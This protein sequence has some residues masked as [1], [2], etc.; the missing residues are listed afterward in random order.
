MLYEVPQVALGVGVGALGEAGGCGGDE[1][2]VEAE[3]E[4][5]QLPRPVVE[6]VELE[7]V[8]VPAGAD[9]EVGV[10]QQARHRGQDGVDVRPPG[11]GGHAPLLLLPD[12]PLDEAAAVDDVRAPAHPEVLGV[13]LPGGHIDHAAQ[14]AAVL[15]PVA[16]GQVVHRVDE[17]G[18]E[19]RHDPA[20][21]VDERDA[22]PVDVD[23]GVLGVGAADDQGAGAQGR[24]RRAR[25]RLDH[26]HRVAERA[27]HAAD[28]LDAEDAP[29][30]VRGL[31]LVD[32][33]DLIIPVAAVLDPQPDAGDLPLG[34]LDLLGDIQVAWIERAET[35]R[36]QRHAAEPV[37]ALG[38]GLC[39]LEEL[40]A[41]GGEG[42]HGDVAELPPGAH[43]DDGALQ[44]DGEVRGVD[45][46]LRGRGLG[47][48]E[49]EGVGE[50]EGDGGRALGVLGGGEEELP[51]GLH[52]GLVEAVAGGLQ[53]L[54]VG[55]LA[56][57]VDLQQEE[58]GALQARL[59]G[60]GRVG[61]GDVLQQLGV[62]DQGEGLLLGVRRGAVVLGE[63][64]AGEEEEERQQGE[65]GAGVEHA[66]PPRRGR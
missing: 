1:A 3:Q 4:E 63:G 22:D 7:L 57:D 13:L 34:D 12:P 52:G 56:V 16:A 55:D 21:V 10:G 17:V 43:L 28:L 9:D 50:L 65:R 19:H 51:G 42:L 40:T 31:L 18:V 37:P 25:Q 58:D 66:T 23:G 44:V 48:L 5:G 24:A 30:D 61:R 39:L 14:A 60:L 2:V 53:H 6:V 47:G 45:L 62:L 59:L 32:A 27:R 11:G 41:V 26:P 54:D 8:V 36:A 64:G 33:D 38:V 15:H 29:G 20:E 46:F 35:D 49:L